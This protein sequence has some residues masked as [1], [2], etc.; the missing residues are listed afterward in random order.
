MT[1]EFL[2]F[3]NQLNLA[4]LN[5]E[6][7]EKAVEKY[8]LLT[9]KAVRNFKYKKNNDGYCDR[10]KLYYQIVNKALPIIEFLYP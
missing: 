6:K 10:A 3:F 2:L 4:S 1:S 8:G 5:L 9:T 7:R